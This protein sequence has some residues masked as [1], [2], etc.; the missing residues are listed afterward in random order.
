MFTAADVY[1]EADA[2]KER[3][4]DLEADVAEQQRLL[5]DAFNDAVHQGAAHL[6]RVKQLESELGRLQ[7]EVKRLESELAKEP[8]FVVW[9]ELQSEIER[10]QCELGRAN[11]QSAA[12]LE[13]VRSLEAELNAR[14][15]HDLA[16]NVR[17]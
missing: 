16:V 2:K 13:R 9:P 15:V 10:L 5:S 12:H 7:N 1:D 3:I 17:M 6:E 14:G 4:E 11:E 8:G